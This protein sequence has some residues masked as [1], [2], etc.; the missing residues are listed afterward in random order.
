MKKVIYLLSIVIFSTSLYSCLDGLNPMNKVSEGDVE[1][2]PVKVDSLYA[3]K[4]PKYMKK[5]SILNDEA[6]LQYMNAYKEAYVIVI[7]ESK[8]LIKATF[9]EMG[10]YNDSISAD[11]NYKNIQLNF[12][13]E[14]IDNLK[15]YDPENITINGLNASLIKLEG[16]VEGYNIFYQLGFIEG[17]QNVYMIMSWTEKSKKERYK[18][19]F[20]KMIESFRLLN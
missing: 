12:I 17:K 7:H 6:S 8:A 11:K 1:M 19:T 2:K 18:R 9:T 20:Q 10:D 5:T 13:K 4:V 3:L 14:T 15:K 16:K